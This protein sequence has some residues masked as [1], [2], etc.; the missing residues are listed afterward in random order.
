MGCTSPI[1]YWGAGPDDLVFVGR[2]RQISRLKWKSRASRRLMEAIV[3]A[4]ACNPVRSARVGLSDH[5]HTPDLE[6]R[7]DDLRAVLDAVGSTQRSWLARGVAG[8]LRHS[9]RRRIPSA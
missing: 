3:G 5:Q 1:G 4:V 2:S 6:M 9:S 7:A 8:R